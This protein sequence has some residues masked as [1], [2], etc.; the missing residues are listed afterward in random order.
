VSLMLD[1][2]EE[3]DSEART[4]A[5]IAREL[6]MQIREIGGSLQA[7]GDPLTFY[8]EC[9][10]MAEVKRT[11]REYDAAGALAESHVCPDSD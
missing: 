4:K 8:C 11:V 7:G 10:C 1:R 5:N 2:G 6:N 3:T 9:G